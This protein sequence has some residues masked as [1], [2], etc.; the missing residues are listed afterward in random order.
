MEG[1]RIRGQRRR[2]RSVAFMIAILTARIVGHDYPATVQQ[3][4]KRCPRACERVRAN[5]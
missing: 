2:N 1:K 4:L 3:D 5:W